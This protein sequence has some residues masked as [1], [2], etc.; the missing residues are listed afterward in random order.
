MR[1]QGKLE[2]DQMELIMQFHFH[3]EKNNKSQIFQIDRKAHV[4]ILSQTGR[5][6]VFWAVA[7]T[8]WADLRWVLAF[9]RHYSR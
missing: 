3:I 4:Q 2:Q 6:L 7:E 9:S 8:I 5:E 1:T